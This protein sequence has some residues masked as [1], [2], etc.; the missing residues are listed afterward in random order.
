MRKEMIKQFESMQPFTKLSVAGRNVKVYS[1]SQIDILL[2]LLKT[3]E[4]IIE[5]IVDTTM[6]Y[7]DDYCEGMATEL[8]KKIYKKI[9]K[10]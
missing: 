8:A 4:E 6:K 5:I 1:K 10:M 7:D 3:K 9:L 2:G